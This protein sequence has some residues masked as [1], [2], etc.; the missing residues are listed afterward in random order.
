MSNLEEQDDLESLKEDVGD[1]VF[2]KPS[3]SNSVQNVDTVAAEAT[4]EADPLVEAEKEK[5]EQKTGSLNIVNPKGQNAEVTKD[6]K[7]EIIADCLISQKWFRTKSHQ[8]SG[9]ISQSKRN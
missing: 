8:K 7:T 3:D 5:E 4:P 6:E 9:M 2:E 1:V